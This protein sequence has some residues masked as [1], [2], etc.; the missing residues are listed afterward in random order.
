MCVVAS[1]D[2]YGGRQGRWF[3]ERCCFVSSKE[4]SIVWGQAKM[5]KRISYKLAAN[6][7]I[8]LTTY[9]TTAIAIAS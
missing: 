7:F 8:S 4:D 5:K 1:A 9:T 6:Y 2:Q 3:N